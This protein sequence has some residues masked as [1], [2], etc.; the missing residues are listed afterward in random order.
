MQHLDVPA[1]D[2]GCA[3]F[4]DFDGTLADLAP[5]P[6]AVAL[7]PGLTDTLQALTRRLD[8]ALAVVSGRPIEQLDR[9]LVPLVLPC[10]GVHGTER[11][12]ANGEMVRIE[13]A[14]DG[15]LDALAHQ[16]EALATQHPGLL[17]ERKPGALAL[18]YRLAPTFEAA[19]LELMERAVS[20]HPG[21]TLLHGKQV[22]EAKPLGASKGNA[23]EAFMAEAPFAGRRPVFAGDDVTD[24]A[25]FAA[26]QRLGGCGIKVGA[27]DT[28]ARWRLPHPAAL[29]R[30][31]QQSVT[32]R[33]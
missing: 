26:V 32:A 24:E 33:T 18:H 23:I 25:G 5:R 11:R 22:V 6:D 15:V 2:A 4:V 7:L 19:C 17:V 29:R 30:W 8:G 16:A 13:T 14:V 12:Q 1:I 3:L 20:V 10:A 31:L 27:G 28:L 9:L 21:L